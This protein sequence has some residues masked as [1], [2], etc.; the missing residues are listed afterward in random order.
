MKTKLKLYT[1]RSGWHTADE[2]KENALQY[3][4]SKAKENEN[5]SWGNEFAK[6]IDEII[7]VETPFNAKKHVFDADSYSEYSCELMDCWLQDMS[8]DKRYTRPVTEDDCVDDNIVF[9]YTDR[10]CNMV[11]RALNRLHYIGAKYFGYDDI[12]ISSM[13]YQEA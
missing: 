1:D 7:E 2:T 11:E 10:G 9:M 13:Y 3:F 12:S 6:T 5:Y 8:K 4:Q